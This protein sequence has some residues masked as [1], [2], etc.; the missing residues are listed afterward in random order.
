[1]R[2]RCAS[3]V[4]DS[5]GAADARAGLAESHRFL[6]DG[7]NGMV[8]LHAAFTWADDT[9]ATAAELARTHRAGVHVHVAEGDFHDQHH[10]LEAR[11]VEVPVVVERLGPS[12][13]TLRSWKGKRT[14]LQ[15]I[16]V[17]W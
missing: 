15:R 6:R 11:P 2:V 5:H 12:F 3:G 17:S 14:W 9:V 10:A 16:I 13:G 8:G 7:G 4:T 1:M